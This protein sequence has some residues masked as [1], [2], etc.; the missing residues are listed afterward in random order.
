MCRLTKIEREFL[1]RAVSRQSERINK[2]GKAL[3]LS[4]CERYGVDFKPTLCQTCWHDAAFLILQAERKMNEAP[5][6]RTIVVR[7]GV[8]VYFNGKRVNDVVVT[9]DSE[10]RRLM[11]EGMAPDY[12]KII[13]TNEDN[14]EDK[15]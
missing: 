1:V 2:E 6:N 14:Y 5:T 12:F 9:T 10:C 3:I 13:Q 4:L 7:E 8:D 11:K 15:I